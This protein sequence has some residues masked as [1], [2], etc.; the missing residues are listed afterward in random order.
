MPGSKKYSV[1]Y[2][3]SVVDKDIPTLSSVWKKK[4]KTAIEA[5]LSTDPE[6]Y[7][8]PLRRSLK[9]FRR[10]RVGDYRIVYLIDKRT[11]LIATI[12]HRSSIYTLA[13]KRFK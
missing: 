7:G 12:G 5:K 11:V 2:L 3:S 13:S 4:I 1:E 6:A 10:L 9:G 8:K